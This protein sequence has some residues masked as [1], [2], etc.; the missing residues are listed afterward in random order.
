MYICASVIR[1]NGMT[2]NK[3]EQEVM[4]LGGICVGR[5]KRR[6]GGLGLNGDHISLYTS[7][8]ISENF[9]DVYNEIVK[10]KQQ[11]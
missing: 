4:K 7:T 2:K 1:L 8:K 9:T 10:K 11:S 6:V 5:N 3:I